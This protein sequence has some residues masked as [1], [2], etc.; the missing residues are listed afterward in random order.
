MPE[1]IPV[2]LAAELKRTSDKEDKDKL[3]EQWKQIKNNEILQL[4]VESLESDLDSLISQDEK[5]DFLSK[6]TSSSKRAKRLGERKRL[7]QLINYFK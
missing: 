4:M 1:R 2:F 3:F 7:R 6:F 5:D